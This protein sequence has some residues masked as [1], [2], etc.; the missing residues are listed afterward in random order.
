M[1]RVQVSM[2]R[3]SDNYEDLEVESQSSRYVTK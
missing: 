2:K 3:G 1:T